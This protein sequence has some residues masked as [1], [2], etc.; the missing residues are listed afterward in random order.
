MNLQVIKNRI[1][2]ILAYTITSVLF[3]IIAAFLALQIPPVQNRLIAYYLKDFSHVT[4]FTSSIR[5][6]RMLWFDRLE[7]RGV[8]VYDPQGNA[9]ISAS[10]VMINFRLLQLIQSNNDVNIDGIYLD[11][12]HVFLTRINESDTS[13]DLNIN[14]FIDRINRNFA[15]SAASTNAGRTPRVNIGEAT[16]NRSQFTYIDQDRDSIRSGFN[17]NQFSVAVNEGQIGGFVLLGDTTQFQVRTLIAEDLATNFKVKQLSTFFRI[18][19]LGMEFID[20]DLQ[21]GRSTITDSIVFRYDSLDDLSDFFDKVKVHA[22]LRKTTVYPKDLAVFLPE[23]GQLR[24]PLEIAGNFTGRISKFKFNQMDVKTGNTHLAG[25]LEMDGLPNISETFIVLNLRDSRLDPEDLAFVLD[26]YALD[27]IRPMGQL[28]MQGQFLGY[29]TDFVANG[30]FS[31]RLGSIRSDINFKVNEDNINLSEYSG[32]LSLNNVDLGTYLDDTAMYQRVTLNGKIIGSGLTKTTADFLLNGSIKSI[33]ING[34][35]YTNIRTDARFATGLVRGLVEID[36][37]NLQFRARGSV[38]LRDGRNQINV[39]AK[40]DTAYLHNLKL[41]RDTIFISTNLQA[42]ISGLTL[43]S[44]KGTAD[45]SNV[46]VLY[47]RQELTLDTI[48]LDA[49]KEVNHRSLKIASTVADAEVSGNYN[50]SNLSYDIETLLEEITLNIRN[51]QP[52]IRAYYRQKTYKPESYEAH[53]NVNLKDIEPLVKLLKIDL[54]VSPDTRLEGRFTSGYTT[55]FNA[56][57]RFDSLTYEGKLFVNTEVELT[58]SKIADSTSILAMATVNSEHQQ[59]AS[60]LKTK[61][62]LAEGIWNKNHIDFGLDADQEDKNNYVRL[63]GAVDFMRDS[64][65]ISMAPSVLKFLE[66]EWNFTA[67]NHIAVQ[68]TDWAFRNLALINAEQ[69]IAVNGY[70]SEDP[71]QVLSLNVSKLD[72]AL[73]NVL[74]ST[75]K[76]GGVMDARIDMRDYYRRPTLGNDLHLKDLTINDFLIGDITGRNVWDTVASRFNFNVAID[77]TGN[78]IVNLNGFYNPSETVSPLNIAARLEKANLNIVEP[79]LTDIFSQIGGTVSGDFRITGELDAPEINGEGAVADGQLMINYLKTMYRFTGNIGLTKSTIYFKDIDMIDVFRNR[80]RL[81]GTISHTNFSNMSI[82]LDATYQNFQVLNTTVKD[83]SLF[84]GQAYATGSL[85]FQGPLSNMLISATARTEKNTRIY[86]PLSGTSSIDKK[87]FINFVNLRDTAVVKTIEKGA[88]S[89]RVNLTGITLDLN[90]DATPDAYCEIIF[91]QK[92]GDIIRGRGNGDLKL[93]LDTKGEFNMFGPFEFTQ[94][95][96][97]F[98]LYDIINKEFEIQKGSRITWYGDPYQATMDIRASYNQQASLA[99]IILDTNLGDVPQLKRKYPVQVLLSL[100][101]P[102]MAPLINF[103]IVAKDLPKNIQTETRTINLDLEFSVF[104]NKLDE[105]ELKRQV[106]SLIVLR[107]FSP[108]ESFDTSGSVVNS[109]SELLSNQ[110]SYWMSQVDQNLVIDVD[111]GMMDQEAFNT[112]QLRFSYTFMG[113]RLRVTGDGTYNNTSTPNTT[114]AQSPSSIAGDW[115]IDYMLT[116]D[117]KLRVKAYSRTS[118]NPILSSV[119]NQNTITTGASIMHTQSFNE[120]RDLWRSSREK[121]K[122]EEEAARRKALEEQRKE[123]A[124]QKK[125]LEDLQKSDEN[126]TQLPEDTE[127]IKAA[128]KDARKEETGGDEADD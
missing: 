19:Q 49:Q 76:F 89:N 100:E 92:A 40:L 95:W 24:D 23:A 31:G 116:A 91:D 112:F 93:Q 128:N 85:N 45:L 63:K 9:M 6:F 41:T 59:F 70:I 26:D 7:L 2:K 97:N 124:R 5:S 114:T 75:L 38:D 51:D 8:H 72:L 28:N 36:D 65:M 20:L 84:Y 44:L 109:V 62:L 107:R 12:A 110:L 50:Y 53:I 52:A 29:P 81:N 32:T 11:S 77:R 71:Y 121:R 42:D 1:K 119:N 120:V 46:R 87:E 10:E 67:D 73:F 98:T 3:L 69:S 68:G 22:R 39:Q 111:L 47:N 83:N 88:K 61:N 54:T 48:H 74:S 56:Y 79:F 99:P 122:A 115:T 60:N 55:I 78:R 15:S 13:R 101:G 18:S 14:V 25:S 33:G 37:P 117:G 34:Y 86:I 30:I 102:M 126:S 123:E 104:K 4:G 127:G 43:D 106:F 66:R 118:V 113:G 94:G 21:A 108:P 105:Q 125:E 58:A 27:R 16:L 90:I 82:G 64:T 103:D 57:T 96:Y 17:Y 80:G 35:N